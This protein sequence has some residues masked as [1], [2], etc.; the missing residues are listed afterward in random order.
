MTRVNEYPQHRFSWKS[1]KYLFAYPSHLELLAF[2]PLWTEKTPPHYLMEASNFN[3]KH[4]W[5]WDLDIF[6][7]KNCYCKLFANRGDPDQMPHS[8][9]SDLGLHCLPITLL[10]VSRL[11]WVNTLTTWLDDKLIIHVFVVIHCTFISDFLFSLK[12]EINTLKCYL[13]IIFLIRSFKLFFL[14]N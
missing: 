6:L 4:V 3:F 9:A 11:Q 7:E 10:E 8:V 2:N 12:N 5:L 14:V 13:L 1:K